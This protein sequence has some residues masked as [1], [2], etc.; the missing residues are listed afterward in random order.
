MILFREPDLLLDDT[1]LS[2]VSRAQ[3]RVGICTACD[4]DLLSLGYY[5]QAGRWMVAARCSACS[6]T[7]LMVYGDDWSWIEDMPL[8]VDEAEERAPA[9]ASLRVSEVPQERL[10]VVFTPAEIRDMIAFQEGR[11]YV[12]QNLYRAR[13][14]LDRFE[15]LFGVRI[16][17]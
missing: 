13:A 12:R 8:V 5:R 15:R 1:K 2:P 7:L 6:R 17:L 14:K 3:N 9:R 4:G 10:E 16:E 11:P